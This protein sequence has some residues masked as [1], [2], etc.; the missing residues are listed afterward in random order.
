MM[1]ASATQAACM[2]PAN[3]HGNATARKA[4]EVSFATKVRRQTGRRGLRDIEGI[5]DCT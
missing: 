1:S 3:S 4:G 2:G 5:S